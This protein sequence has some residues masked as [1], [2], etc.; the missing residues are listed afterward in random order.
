MRLEGKAAVITGASSGIGKATA[1]LFVKEGAC[2][3]GVARRGAVLEEIAASL[4]GQPGKLIPYVGDIASQET[5]EGM[6][7]KAIEVFGKVDI[8]VNNAG[9]IDQGMTTEHITNEIW[10]NTM[11]INLTAP[12]YATRYFLQKKLAKEEPG[13]IVSVSSVGGNAHP[14]IC[15]CAYAASKAGL[16]QLTK[17]VAYAYGKKNIRCNAICVGACPTTGIAATFTNPDMEGMAF[18]GAVNALSIRNAEPIELAQAILFLS[19]D[20]ASYVNG[21]ILNV[22]GGWSA[23]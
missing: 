17:H 15:G 19:S 23:I 21:A 4:E 2:V 18:S 14:L 9:V 13:N 5:N 7:D 3:V 6:I 11:Q 20:D 12:M 1:E 10:D 8:L 16:L 22:D